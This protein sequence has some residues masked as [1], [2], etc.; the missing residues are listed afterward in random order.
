M[1]NKEY[2]PREID[3]FLNNRKTVLANRR[4]VLA[5]N[6]SEYEK[7]VIEILIDEGYDKRETIQM[8]KNGQVEYYNDT[9]SN[10]LYDWIQ[11]GNFPIKRLMDCIDYE[12]LDRALM[13]EGTDVIEWRDENNEPRVLVIHE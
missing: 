7:E 8:V 3:R 11:L 12:M 1:R 5:E 4:A 9:F 2:S 10:V 13:S 6:L